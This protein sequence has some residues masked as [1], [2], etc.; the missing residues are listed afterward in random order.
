M[1]LFR[2]PQSLE[3]GRG[4]EI[5]YTPWFVR[6]QLTPSPVWTHHL[7]FS[8]HEPGSANRSLVTIAFG[9]GGFAG[10]EVRP[11]SAEVEGKVTVTVFPDSTVTGRSSGWSADLT[12]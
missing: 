12:R 1:R 10:A 6:S 7:S 4:M 5:T 3:S 9:G 8:L 11:L 2:I